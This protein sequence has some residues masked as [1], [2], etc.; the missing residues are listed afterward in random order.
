MIA[1]ANAKINLG[2]HVLNKRPDGYHNLE[3]VFYPIPLFDVVEMVACE[4]SDVRFFS[5][6]KEIPGES[7]SNL[8]IRA[9]E[10]L[11]QDFDLPAVEIHLLKN[12]PIGAGL[13]GGSS[14]A[15]Q[16]LKMANSF[17][18]LKISDS[19]LTQY[20]RGLGA[21][22]AFFVQNIPC[23]GRGKGDELSPI[24][25]DL[26]S[27]KMVL[28][29]PDIHVSTADAYASVKPDPG[30]KGLAHAVLQDP[31]LW[32]NC[33]SN[34]FEGPIFAKYPELAGLKRR[35]Y[36]DGALYVSMS[37]SGPSIFALFKQD[38]PLNLEKFA[39]SIHQFDL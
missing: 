23:F 21:D 4:G 5:Y 3:T 25:M 12:I 30:S 9:Y 18:D 14:D 34:D 33:I 37:G 32:K 20:A 28:L 31:G 16:V 19:V 24:A 6:G 8:C 1:F 36:D 11:R 35:L 39:C 13:G 7:Q 15:V 2:L 38:F 22:C 29:T 26:S 10:L 27:Y 17:F